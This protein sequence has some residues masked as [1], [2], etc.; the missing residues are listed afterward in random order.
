M[1]STLARG[2]RTNRCT[3]RRNIMI[4]AP[5]DSQ[6]IRWVGLVPTLAAMA[7]AAIQFI[8]RAQVDWT[9]DCSL[10][11]LC[12]TQNPPALSSSYGGWLPAFLAFAVLYVAMVRHPPEIEPSR[13]D[14]AA[15]LIVF[16]A[17]S[18]FPVVGWYLFYAGVAA[19]FL[20]A[21][22]VV[23]LPLAPVA[24]VLGAGLIGGL[25]LGVVAGPSWT[26]AT[27]DVWRRWLLCH[28]NWSAVA[29]LVFTGGHVLFDPQFRGH[30]TVANGF[31]VLG[32]VSATALACTIVWR[33]AGARALVPATNQ[34]RG[35]FQTYLMIAGAAVVLTA[36][37]S[38][39]IARGTTLLSRDGG[40]TDPIANFVR[41][42]K[43]P[44]SVNLS[45]AGLDFVGER[46][47]I[48]ARTGVDR[49]RMIHERKDVG[50]PREATY[51]RSVIDRIPTWHVAP[52]AKGQQAI[53][54]TADNGGITI[55]LHCQA[56]QRDRRL[57][58]RERNLREG[59]THSEFSPDWTTHTVAADHE[60]GYQFSSA[61]PDAALG[62]RY[63]ARS[64]SEN[65]TSTDWHFVYCRL[66]LINVTEAK[67]S[68]HQII[69][70]DTPWEVRARDI[71]SYVESLFVR[72]P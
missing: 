17:A 24:G 2:F 16:I 1:A 69:P 42:S 14:R 64:Q 6:P 3:R 49:A 70:C 45:F 29:A 27:I 35:N 15:R 54:L 60:D 33:L 52:P 13:A 32:V 30:G 19:G 23:A 57:C 67:L 72:R 44:I 40:L 53:H 18:L 41:G 61:L 59:Q 5:R 46:S 48:L 58:V 8:E 26:N 31:A 62:Y 20:A 37:A 65:T 25:I 10:P 56:D 68:V 55:E 51:S 47:L 43:P 28:A 22:T 21:I 7:V 66:N 39:A 9:A 12:A 63:A 71:R 11:G 4:R 36:L 38:L 50:T 34:A